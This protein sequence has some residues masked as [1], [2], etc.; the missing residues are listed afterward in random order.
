MKRTLMIKMTQ[1][2][3]AATLICGA[4][5]TVSSCSGN[6]DKAVSA[7]PESELSE[8]PDYS[9]KHNWMKLPEATK[10]VDCFYVYPTE[11]VDDS[12]GA[13]LFADIND[14]GMRTPASRVQTE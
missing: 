2:V 10:D 6:K 14:M 7:N 5:V 11:Y 13:P 3:I 8:A 9:D 4:H 1:W 12:E